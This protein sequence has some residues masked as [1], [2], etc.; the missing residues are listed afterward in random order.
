[1]KKADEHRREMEA[2]RERLTRLRQ[3][4][5]ATAASTAFPPLLRTST[6]TW[7]AI[8]CAVATAPCSTTTSSLS[9]R[10]T[11]RVFN[12]P[13]QQPIRTRR[14]QCLDRRCTD[15]YLKVVLQHDSLEKRGYRR[16]A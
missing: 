9:G 12:G 8:G 1:M 10:Q 16:S 2:L 14:P 5:V 15:T 11:L 3:K 7:A 6:S 4:P 13:G